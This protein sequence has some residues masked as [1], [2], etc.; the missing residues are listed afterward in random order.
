VW[1]FPPVESVNEAVPDAVHCL[2]APSEIDEGKLAGVFES[3]NPEQEAPPPPDVR[4]AVQITEPAEPSWTPVI[5]GEKALS[6][7]EGTPGEKVYVFWYW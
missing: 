3:A 1:A 2:V 6:Q 5:T 4:V 7:V